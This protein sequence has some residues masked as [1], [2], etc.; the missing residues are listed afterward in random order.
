MGGTTMSGV[1]Q[2]LQFLRNITLYQANHARKIQF[3]LVDFQLVLSFLINYELNF[4]HSTCAFLVQVIHETNSDLNSD[5]NRS[6]AIILSISFEDTTCQGIRHETETY[7]AMVLTFKIK[8]KKDCTK[9]ASVVRLCNI[10]EV[11]KPNSKMTLLY[12]KIV[13]M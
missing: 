4:I 10:S 2:C 5:L 8:L 9:N 11:V 7:A 1:Q 13:V 12:S 3:A 6:E